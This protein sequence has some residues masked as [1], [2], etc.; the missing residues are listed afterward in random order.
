MAGG[1][2][3]QGIGNQY[4]PVSISEQGMPINLMSGAASGGTP[5]W[6]SPSEAELNGTA[7]GQDAFG[8]IGQSPDWLQNYYQNHLIQEGNQGYYAP[9]LQLRDMQN[10]YA[11][12]VQDLYRQQGQNFNNPYWYQQGFTNFD[13]FQYSQG[14]Y[15]GIHMPNYNSG[16]YN[17]ARFRNPWTGADASLATYNNNGSRT[18]NYGGNLYD[19][20]TNTKWGGNK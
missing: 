6:Q 12:Q 18:R 3:A 20:F 16:D 15:T 1:Y 5:N 10:Q 7:A 19:P 8:A 4:Q 11:P 17:D 13:P 14:G 9:E 2:Y